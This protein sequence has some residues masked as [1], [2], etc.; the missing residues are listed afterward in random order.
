MVIGEGASFSSF[1]EYPEPR[2][3]SVHLF[4]KSIFY[5]YSVVKQSINS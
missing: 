4:K 3:N 5:E 2:N 1:L